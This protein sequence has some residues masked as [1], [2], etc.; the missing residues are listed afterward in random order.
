MAVSDVELGLPELRAL[1]RCTG[2]ALQPPCVI[3]LAGE[4]GAGKTT[5][6]QALCEGLGVSEPVTSPTYA[7]V[8]EYASAR[9]PVH[10]VD[11]YRLRDP[12]QLAQLGW[13]D[14]LSV[15]GIVIV[16]WPERA[17]DRMPPDARWY[18]L[19]HVPGRSDRRRLGTSGADA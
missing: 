14:L 12:S 16:E 18:T 11:L 15:G 6:A 1:A 2:A 10:H 19:G 5:F 3:A 7:L 13:D 8:H 9:G 4:L 17:G